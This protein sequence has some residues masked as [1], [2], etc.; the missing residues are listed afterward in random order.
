MTFA[1]E[2]MGKKTYNN[3]VK[4]LE[5]YQNLSKLDYISQF[6]N[7]D[8]W[9]ICKNTWVHIGN[10]ILHTSFLHLA[11]DC[12][13]KL[14]NAIQFTKTAQKK[15]GV[16]NLF[17]LSKWRPLPQF[18]LIHKIC[19]QTTWSLV[20][21]EIENIQWNPF[22]TKSLVHLFWRAD[23]SAIRCPAESP[24]FGGFARAD[25]P[26]APHPLG[27][28]DRQR[29]D[30]RWRRRRRAAPASGCLRLGLAPGRKRKPPSLTTSRISRSI[31]GWWAI[32]V[33]RR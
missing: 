6:R 1:E 33:M 7:Y 30:A 16:C 10:L 12:S 4:C 8:I 23:F 20:S 11:R 14:Q 2:E 29:R 31:R 24:L 15:G 9:L 25:R 13:S 18:S 28:A 32:D 3:F 17:A 19:N 21:S 26:L 22:K 5:I 27:D